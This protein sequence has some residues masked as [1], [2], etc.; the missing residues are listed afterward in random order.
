VAAAGLE[1]GAASVHSIKRVANSPA[2][3]RWLV[4]LVKLCLMDE[5]KQG[6][7]MDKVA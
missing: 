4:T 5:P 7:S 3:R 1:A 2:V 6:W